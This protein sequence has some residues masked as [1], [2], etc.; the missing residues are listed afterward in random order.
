MDRHLRNYEG[1][2]LSPGFERLV[3]LRKSAG[4]IRF[5]HRFDERDEKP[6]K[7]L[8]LDK[9]TEIVTQGPYLK[10]MFPV[11]ESPYKEMSNPSKFPAWIHLKKDRADFHTGCASRP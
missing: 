3:H 6:G 10:D 4:G 5:Q 8:V 1:R 9:E 2:L 7:V 11:H